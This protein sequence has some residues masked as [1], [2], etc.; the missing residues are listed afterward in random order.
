MYLGRQIKTSQ[1]S[2]TDPVSVSEI[3]LSIPSGIKAFPYHP[4]LSLP[5][6]T[7]KVSGAILDRS[8]KSVDR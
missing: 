7:A 4:F 8:V 5:C 3:M 2:S 6:L 1:F